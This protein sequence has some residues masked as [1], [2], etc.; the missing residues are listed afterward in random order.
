M[1]LKLYIKTEIFAWPKPCIVPE[2]IKF[3][4]A[5]DSTIHGGVKSSETQASAMLP[6]M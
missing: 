2:A 6:H 4:S 1:Y 3:I 5:M